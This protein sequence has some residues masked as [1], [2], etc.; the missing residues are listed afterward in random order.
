MTQMIA[1]KNRLRYYKR[2]LIIGGVCLIVNYIATGLY[3]AYKHQQRMD[4]R[5]FANIQAQKDRMR[6]SSQKFDEDF[7]RRRQEFGQLSK[8]AND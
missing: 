6:S 3:E 1:A 2:E 4:D 5:I 7:A 8:K